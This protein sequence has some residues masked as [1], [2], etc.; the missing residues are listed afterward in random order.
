MEINL[1]D[2]AMIYTF[3]VHAFIRLTISP[4]RRETSRDHRRQPLVVL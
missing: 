4:A 2:E 1:A 3:Y